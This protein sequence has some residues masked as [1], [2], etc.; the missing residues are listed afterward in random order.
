MRTQYRLELSGQSFGRW[1]VIE[2]GDIGRNGEIF[3]ACR[4]SCGTERM[5]LARLLRSGG[6][7]S[8]GCNRR[9]HGLT[10]SGTH[11]S[12]ESMFQRC[13]NQNAPDFPRYGGRGIQICERWGSFESFLSDMGVR[14]E[15]KSL[16]RIDN[17]KNYT[18]ENCKWSTPQEQQQNKSNCPTVEYEGQQITISALA[19]SK[20]VPIKVLKWRLDHQWD[21][22][23][24]LETPV[25]MK[26]N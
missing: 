22:N 8:C 24:A 23:R 19:T 20:G 7:T 16:D 12:W 18:P 14:P 21:L 4:C 3:W 10:K 17:S 13:T 9:T 5:V 1:T 11:K 2:K 26:R 6:S 15:G 25:R